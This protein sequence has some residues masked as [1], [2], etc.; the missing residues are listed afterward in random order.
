MIEMYEKQP[1]NVP[2]ILNFTCVFKQ[3]QPTAI[4]GKTK[5]IILASKK[6]SCIH[7]LFMIATEIREGQT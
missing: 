7:T 2:A 3:H 4:E 1:D 6:S 5:V